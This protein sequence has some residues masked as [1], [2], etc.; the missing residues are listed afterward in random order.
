M[1]ANP[2]VDLFSRAANRLGELDARQPEIGPWEA[3]AL[4]Q[5]PAYGFGRPL[6]EVKRMSGSV[7]AGSS[8]SSRTGVTGSGATRWEI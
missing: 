1:D 7:R 4:V 8:V 5:E 2:S 3:S 6:S